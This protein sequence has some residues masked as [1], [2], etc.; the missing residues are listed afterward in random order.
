MPTLIIL[1]SYTDF[2]IF[3]DILYNK[4]IMGR[5]IKIIATLLILLWFADLF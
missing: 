4:P 5:T 1:D 2:A 3:L